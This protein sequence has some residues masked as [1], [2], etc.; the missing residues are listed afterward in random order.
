MKYFGT[1][2]IRGEVGKD[3]PYHRAFQV[4]YSLNKIYINKKVYIA[5]DGRE[6][7]PKYISALIKAFDNL[8]YEV[9]GMYPTPTL[10]F[11]SK[12]NNA[13]G[14]VV[15]ASHNKFSDNGI[16]I[17]IDGRKPSEKEI[18]TIEKYM[19]LSPFYKL[20]KI[21]YF[22]TNN[23]NEYL[24]FLKSQNLQLNYSKNTIFDCANGSVSSIVSEIFSGN[25]L[26]NTPNGKNI[27]HNCGT[28]NIEKNFKNKK[29]HEL[30]I[31]YDGD[32]DRML[33]KIKKHIIYGDA[34]LYLLSK[35]ESQK[36]IFY[37]IALSI[38][39]NPGIIEAFEKLGIEVYETKV[40]DKYILDAV[41]KNIAK[42]GAESSGHIITELISIGDGILSS[43][44]LLD[45]IERRGIDQINEWLNEINLFPM[46]TI[47][48]NVSKSILNEESTKIKL[49]EI[50]EMLPKKSKMIVRPSGT[51]DL[52]RVTVS[53]KD[54][55]ITDK[56]IKKVIKFLKGEK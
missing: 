45:L 42:R 51:E 21:D 23:I 1:D 36:N 34:F 30:V 40:G 9:L 56:I 10:A 50:K 13:I 25:F 22:E 41:S 12:I 29:E 3:F 18:E 52:I 24:N 54:E 49:S 27:N 2:G 8:E 6:S 46:K 43:M 47:N 15:T 38:M 32:G 48:L 44:I 20:K 37:K 55:K 11:I 7:H 26:F 16:K 35:D 33:A 31:S 5:H 19:D 28:T 4:G 14:V 17:F 39:T 53:A